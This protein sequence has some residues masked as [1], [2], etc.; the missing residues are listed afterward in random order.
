MKPTVAISASPSPDGGD[1]AN[2]SLVQTLKVMTAEIVEGGNA[3][4]P[5]VSAKFNDKGEVTDPPRNR[6]FACYLPLLIGQLTATD[7]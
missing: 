4:Y 1:K 7:R 6:H 3:L 2:A 5:A